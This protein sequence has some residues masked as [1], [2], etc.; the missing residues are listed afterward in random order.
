MI[1]VAADGQVTTP[2]GVINPAAVREARILLPSLVS[3]APSHRSRLTEQYLR[4]IPQ[5]VPANAGWADNWITEHTSEA[6]QTELLDALESAF[7]RAPAAPDAPSDVFRYQVAALDPK[8][9]EFK[10]VVK[11]Y[12]TTKQDGVHSSAQLTPKRVYAL[13]DLRRGAE[14]DAAHQQVRNVQQL[15][16]GTS[17]ANMLSILAKGLYVPPTHGSG[18]RIAG[19]M[20]GD[21]IYLSESASKSLNYSTGFWGGGRQ[22]STFMLLTETAMGSEYR[23]EG[24]GYDPSASRRARTEMNKFG[25]PYNSI[26]VRPGRA[27]VINHEAIVWD[28][29]Q[30]RL[31]WLLEF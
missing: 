12:N 14:V 28:A 3:A 7:S 5:K 24:R 15:W 16:H 17:A 30:V 11:H 27:G 10:Q 8:S 31:R 23:P 1:T 21:G 4:L 20:F 26:N 29:D 2:L 9:A 19:R 18:I 6:K 13:T 25:K 22:A